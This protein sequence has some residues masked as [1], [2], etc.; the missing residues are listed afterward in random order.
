MEGSEPQ[1]GFH[2]PEA[3]QTGTYANFLGVW[4]TGHEFTLDFSVTMR[5]SRVIPQRFPERITII[6]PGKG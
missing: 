1:F 4:H 5:W 6:R 2:V 3:L